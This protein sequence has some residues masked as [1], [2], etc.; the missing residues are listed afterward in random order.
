MRRALPATNV[1]SAGTAATPN[2]SDASAL[3]PSTN[4]P[5][6]QNLLTLPSPGK[7]ALSV[8]LFPASVKGL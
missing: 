8:S 1:T 5:S 6:A 2:E 3:S 7:R 4:N